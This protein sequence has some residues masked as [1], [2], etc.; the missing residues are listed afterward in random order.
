MPDDSVD[1]VVLPVPTPWPMVLALGIALLIAGMV[2]HWAISV[3]GAVLLVR[4]SI[5]WFSM[6]CP[7]NI[8]FQSRLISRRLE[9]PAAAQHAC[10]HG[11]TQGTANCCLPRRIA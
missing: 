6:Y 11:S 4:S 9:S 5:G 2:T 7:T 1:E 8:T 3:L 10:S